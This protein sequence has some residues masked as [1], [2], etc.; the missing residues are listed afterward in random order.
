MP[1]VELALT[2]VGQ[3]F[4]NQGIKTDSALPVNAFA[5][6]SFA[7]MRRK[8]VCNLGSVPLERDALDVSD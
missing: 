7:Q 3:G 8:D 1:R 5:Q 4:D 6:T 2:S